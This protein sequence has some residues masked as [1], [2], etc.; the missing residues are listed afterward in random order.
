MSVLPA[1]GAS[2]A[3]EAPVV[4]IGAGAAGLTAA[5]AARDAG[6]DALVIE[7][8]PA[9]R[10]STALSA[11]LIPAAGTRW[12][13]AAGVED[14]APAFAADIMAKAQGAA[15]AAL[16]ET[17]SRAAGPALEWLADSHGLP[18]GLVD[19]FRYPGHSVLR[20]HGLP[21]RSGAELMDRLREAAVGAGAE[22]VCDAH[23]TALFVHRDGNVAG[24]HRARVRTVARSISRAASLVLACGGYGGDTMLVSRHIPEMAGALYFGHAG[25]Q[26]D[27]LRWGEAL[28][29]ATRDLAGYQGHGSVAHPHGDS[30][31]LGDDHRRWGSGECRRT[32][33]LRRNER[34]FRAGNR[35]SGA[36]GRHRLDRVR[37]SHRRGLRASSRISVTRKR[38]APSC[39]R[40]TPPSLRDRQG[41]PPRLWPRRSTPSTG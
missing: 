38:R 10:G 41:F 17:V 1:E 23:A 39:P 18:I 15:D 29:A 3:A 32:A 28:G 22:L 12:Q 36:A 13:R 9:P 27:A 26:G 21:S 25:N 30:H 24:A 6:L 7:R 11:G 8:D 4:I 2:F 20:M 19:D 34:L 37:R 31:H 14:S 33:L 5:L 35:R 40:R 16:V